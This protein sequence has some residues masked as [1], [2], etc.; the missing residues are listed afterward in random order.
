MRRKN[1]ALFSEAYHET[2]AV[3]LI[4]VIANGGIDGVAKRLRNAEANP[5]ATMLRATVD[6]HKWLENL[7][8]LICRD[9]VA[10]IAHQKF[11]MTGSHL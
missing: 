9:A 4:G 5:T 3:G 2:S 7:T 8:D 11:T 1:S 10:I 6:T